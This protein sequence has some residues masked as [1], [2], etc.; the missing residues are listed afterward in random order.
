MGSLVEIIFLLLDVLWYLILAQI[1]MSWLINFGILN[2]N[3]PMVVQIWSSLN[4][5]L[6]PIYSRVRNFLPSISGIDLAPLVVIVGIIAIR[7]II[8]NNA[9][10]LM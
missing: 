1:I 5:L 3:Q 6:E 4:R 10:S 9:A 2:M 7:I 8:S